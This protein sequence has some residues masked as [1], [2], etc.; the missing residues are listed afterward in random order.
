M[1][2]AFAVWSVG[3][4]GEVRVVTLHS[5]HRVSRVPPDVIVFR[6]FVGPISSLPRSLLFLHPATNSHASH[7]YSMSL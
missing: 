1:T 7:T 5:P 2:I 4:S 6:P 3:G